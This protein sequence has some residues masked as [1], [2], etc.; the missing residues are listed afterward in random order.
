MTVSQGPESQE[1]LVAQFRERLVRDGLTHEGDTM[2]P[3]DFTLM[4]FLRARSFDTEAATTM[5][6]K[7]Q[8]W[9]KSVDGVGID[10]IYKQMDPYDFPE[11]REVF[12]YWPMW[13]HKTD[14]A[15]RPV[16]IQHYGGVNMSELYKQITPERFWHYMLATA[17]SIP[18]DILPA[19]SRKVGRQVDG[20]FLI[21]DLKGFSLS[22]FW[23]MKDIA[24]D[25][26]QMSQDNFPEVS[27]K[28]YIINA[29]SS[30]TIIWSFVK[31]WLSK[32]TV[33]KMDILGSEYHP[34]LLEHIDAESL[35]ASLG[36]KCECKDVGGCKWIQIDRE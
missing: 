19:A 28:F 1:A 30:F 24:R 35:P 23:Q 8:A 6:I 4:R 32:N 12:E 25:A 22:Q 13:F 18:R 16:N 3:D 11:R 14:K 10:E 9:R 26:F 7:C 17:E 2:A 34:V 20:T 5:W 27:S 29:P 33:D 21:V 36:G 31:R 15:G